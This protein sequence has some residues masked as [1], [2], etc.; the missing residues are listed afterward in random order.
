MNIRKFVDKNY[1]KMSLKQLVSA[2]VNALQGL[3]E[4]D[5]KTLKEAFRIKTIADLAKLKYVKWAQAICL[6]AEGEDRTFFRYMNINK[7]LDKEYEK[8]SFVQLKNVPFEALQGVSENDAILL[9]KAFNKRR[10]SKY[11]NIAQAI[12]TLAEAEELK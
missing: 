10:L 4:N 6:L 8:M 9:K 7:F 11:V 5:A 1:E 2:P 12:V 3:N